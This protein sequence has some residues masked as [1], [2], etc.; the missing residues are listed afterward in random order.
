MMISL[1][2]ARLATT[3][4][5]DEIN[6]CCVARMMMREQRARVRDRTMICIVFSIFDRW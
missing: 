1:L 5:I 2:L 6:Y 3:S 4:F